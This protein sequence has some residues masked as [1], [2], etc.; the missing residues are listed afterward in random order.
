MKVIFTTGMSHAGWIS[1]IHGRLFLKILAYK[2]EIENKCM[3]PRGTGRWQ[4]ELGDWGWHIHTPGTLY[5]MDN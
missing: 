5:R 3:I 4:D 1:K 2:A